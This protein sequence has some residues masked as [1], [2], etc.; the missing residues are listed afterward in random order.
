MSATQDIRS[1]VRHRKESRTDLLRRVA[2]MEKAHAAKVAR[3]NAE[4]DSLVCALRKAATEVDAKDRALST[5]VAIS[6]GRLQKIGELEGEAKFQ[7]GKVVRAE[8]NVRRLV[9]S[10][11]NTQKALADAQ[12]R[13]SVGPAPLVPPFAPRAL[14]GQNPDDTQPIPFGK[15][16]TFPADPDDETAVDIALANFLAQPGVDPRTLADQFAAGASKVTVS[17]GIWA[18]AT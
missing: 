9:A 16:L 11:K 8:V 1:A 4:N 5:E 10:L 17:G 2:Y 13:L 14:R 12:P 15:W 18:A 6:V 3:L 7:A